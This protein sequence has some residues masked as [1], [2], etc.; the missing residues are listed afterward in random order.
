MADPQ[1]WRNARPAPQLS[2][3]EGRLQPPHALKLLWAWLPALCWAAVIFS[4]STDSFSAEHTGRILRPILFWLIP[5]LTEAGFAQLHFLVRKTAHFTEYFV[6]CLLL[7]RG[8]RGG[9]RG[10]RWS[11]GVAALAIAAGY[12]A[13]DEIHQA[14]VASRTASPYDSMLDTVGAAFAILV[15]WLWFRAKVPSPR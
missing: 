13:L 6:F 2:Q 9:E 7:Y 1:P 14:F 4:L 12:S 5:S 15:L 11:W 8:I 10:W 3:M